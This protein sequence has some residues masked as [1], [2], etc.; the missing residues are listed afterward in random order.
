[1]RLTAGDGTPLVLGRIQYDLTT[2]AAPVPDDAPNPGALPHM[3]VLAGSEAVDS[4]GG[5]LGGLVEFRNTTLA[6]LLGDPQQQGALNVLAQRIAD[7]ANKQLAAGN[8]GPLF[9]YTAGDPTGAAAAF[10]VDPARTAADLLWPSAAPS[11]SEPGDLADFA[12]G[13][14]QK[15]AIDYQSASDARGLY[16]A[17][18][19]QARTAREQQSGVSVETEM[20]NLLE[21]QRSYQ[22]AAKVVSVLNQLVDNVLAVVG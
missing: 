10:T 12:T 13:I 17:L 16:S 3:R 22:A 9:A 11:S 8:T 6:R 5:E 14:A 7:E 2:G 1:V 21:F 15:I 20:V 19:D 4:P 18:G